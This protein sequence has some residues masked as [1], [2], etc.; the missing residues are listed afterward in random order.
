MFNQSDFEGDTDMTVSREQMKR[1]LML[2]G[3]LVEDYD[4]E[5]PV[6]KTYDGRKILQWL[7]Y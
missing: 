4:A 7:G 6:S 2:H 3:V 1:E 5:H